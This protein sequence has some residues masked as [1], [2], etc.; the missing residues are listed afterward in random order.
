MGFGAS[1]VTD[2]L[3][4]DRLWEYKKTEVS[5]ALEGGMT[6]PGLELHTA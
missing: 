6:P 5:I 2:A 3:A 4:K 1:R